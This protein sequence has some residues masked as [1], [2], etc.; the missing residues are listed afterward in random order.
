MTSREDQIQAIIN[1]LRPYSLDI[2]RAGLK[3]EV[4]IRC[5]GYPPTF[6]IASDTLTIIHATP[7]LLARVNTLNPNLTLE[8]LQDIIDTVILSPN[9]E[10]ENCA[11]LQSKTLLLR[12]IA[13]GILNA[14]PQLKS[15]H[16]S[17]LPKW[18]WIVLIILLIIILAW[19][20]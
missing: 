2:Q 13:P 19:Y 11:Y 18:L 12:L 16:P 10:G 9:V 8:Q 14:Q 20:K 5:P 7:D 3:P 15:T 1:Q 6:P 17:R 4:M